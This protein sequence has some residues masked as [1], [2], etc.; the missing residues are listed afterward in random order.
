VTIV[1]ILRG[2]APIVDITS[3]TKLLAGDELVFTGREQDGAAFRD[4]LLRGV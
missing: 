4:Y 2:S 3:D 1:A